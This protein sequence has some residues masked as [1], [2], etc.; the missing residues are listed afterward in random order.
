[1]VA[2]SNSRFDMYAALPLLR[3][4]EAVDCSDEDH[5]QFMA[6]IEAAEAKLPKY[7]QRGRTSLRYCT[8]EENAVWLAEIKADEEALGIDTAPPT[9]AVEICGT[10]RK[11]EESRDKALYQVSLPPEQFKRLRADDDELGR[12][13]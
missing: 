2:A 12:G 6:E 5:E 9:I 4:G 3:P 13:K 8:N 10:Y 11:I 7:V 1:M